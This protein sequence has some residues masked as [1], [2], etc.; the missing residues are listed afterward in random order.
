M[1]LLNG[2]SKETLARNIAELYE[3]N[4]SKS[5]GKKRSHAQIIAIAEAV[6]RR[7]K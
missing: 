7:S 4:K 3:A 2:K 5:P 1:P 6:K